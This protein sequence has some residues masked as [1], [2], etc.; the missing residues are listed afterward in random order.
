MELILMLVIAAA[1]NIGTSAGDYYIRSFHAATPRQRLQLLNQAVELNPNHVPALR[2]RALVRSVLGEKKQAFADIIRAA[3]LSPGDPEI[4]L[5]AAAYA[6]EL[7][8]YHPAARFYGRALACEWTNPFVRARL[9][10]ALIKIRRTGQALKHADLLVQRLPREDFPYAVRAEVYE[11]A[12]RFQDAVGDLSVLV[13]RHPN[14]SKYYLR[15][16]IN[17]RA[18]GAGRKA[19]A[20]A[21]KSIPLRG[22]SGY[23]Y[24][25]RGCSYEVLGELDRALQ[26]YRKAAEL[27]DD[28]RYYMIWSCI[29]LR[30]QGNRAQADK[31]IKNFLRQLEEDGWIAPVIKYLAGEIE[32][33]D[34][35]RLARH[36]DPETTRQRLCEAYYY[37]GA[38]YLADNRLDRAE[39]FFRKC[40]A[41]HVNNFYEHG[42]AIRDLRTIEKMRAEKAPAHKEP[43]V[44][45]EDN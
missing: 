6:E 16:C 19:L 2:H 13:R 21:E 24:A 33:E 28:K 34:V 41:Q 39:E 7:K 10:Q 40:L 11:W 12:S 26:D 43:R 1:G 23:V 38:C 14:D 18:M 22:L 36:K 37:I 31:L 4:N 27:D 9:I 17:Y 30:K 8:K 42:F 32:E 3:E 20:D 5:A 35:L 29:I 25:A 45:D 15:R 44:V